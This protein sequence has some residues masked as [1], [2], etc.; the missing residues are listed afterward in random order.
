M[1]EE[2]R[3]KPE[4]AR[5]SVDLNCDLGESYGSFVIGCD[6]EVMKYISSANIACGWHGGDPVVME[7]TVKTAKKNGIVIG[8]HP[9]YP[10]LMG[11]GRRKMLLSADEV[12][13]Y[14]KYQLG[15]FWA[16]A[17]S[18]DMEVAHI[19]PH[20]AMYNDAGVD[21][22]MARAIAEAVVEINPDIAFMALAGSQMVKAAEDTG[23]RVI[24]EFFADRA[25]EEDGNL[26]ARSKPGAIIHDEIICV[27]RIIKMLKY[28]TVAAISGKEINIAAD[29]ICVH[30]DNP[31]AL[32]FVKK[33]TESLTNEGFTIAPAT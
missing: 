27:E 21:Y 2:L 13:A 15:A 30:G 23:L 24:S 28:G 32:Q 5:R 19:K 31:Q 11:F 6:E 20:G 17:K 10:D 1:K 25:Y 18:N 4:S 26:V 16:F 22:T 29:S 12:K 7:R 33:I 3:L 14:T 8:A 9:S